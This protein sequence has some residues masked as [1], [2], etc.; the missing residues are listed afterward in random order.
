MA[1]AANWNFAGRIVEHLGPDSQLIDSAAGGSVGSDDL[2]RLI[3]AHGSSLL[4]AGLKQGDRVLI[5]CTLSV[6][7]ALAYLGAMYAG[8]VAVPVDERML[9]GSTVALIEATGARAV[10]SETAATL[11]LAGALRL[12]GDPAPECSTSL[13]PARCAESDLAALMATSGSTGIPR[14]V[15][16]SHGNLVANTEA[17]VRSQRLGAGERAM[18]VLPVS[19]CF[20]AS[21]LHSHFYAGGSVVFDRRFMFPD[22]VLQAINDFRCTTFAGV[23]TVY[24]VLLTRSSLQRMAFPSLRRF[25]QAGGALAPAKVG[26]MRAAFPD[27]EFFV[28]Y[29]QTEA[30]ARISCMDPRRWEEKPGSAGKPLDNLTVRIVDEDGNVL[31]PGQTGQLLVSGPSI[32]GGYWNDPEETHRVLRDGWLH[33]GDLARQ[34]RE[35]YLWIEGRIGTFLKIRGTRVSLTEIEGKVAAMPGVYECAACA[36]EHPEAGDA[37][38]LL[39][40]PDRGAQIDVEQIRRGLPAHWTLDSIRLVPELP[41]TSTGKLARAE[42]LDWAKKGYAAIG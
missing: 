4:A 1:S 15:K 33:T 27:I 24:N 18:V 29:G 13:E 30:T 37:L 32:C 10:W 7:S 35:G 21:L 9:A 6:S 5:G 36:V 41:R 38:M 20:G 26:E 11:E 39:V 12:Q 40:V 14:F 17:I 34:D 25:L 8:M 2:R 28:M 19:Y 23:P 42:L 22:K 31:A 16:V 3:A